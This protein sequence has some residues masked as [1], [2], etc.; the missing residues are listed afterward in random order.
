V[1]KIFSFITQNQILSGTG[2]IILVGIGILLK[3]TFLK[4]IVNAG[5]QPKDKSSYKILFIDDQ[6]FRIIDILKKNGWSSAKR[7]KDISSLDDNDVR[8]SRILF[9]DINGVGK[10]LS[11]TDEGKG[12]AKA[13]REKY[14]KKR[15]VLYS[16]ESQIF[17]AVL[18]M[19]DKCL[20]K[21]AD[22]YEFERIIEDYF[23]KDEF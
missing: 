19:V 3:K 23:E 5:N 18:S 22:Q 2:T 1:E 11:F 9:I 14:P 6:P 12:L 10:S 13:I 15:I 20:Y 21:N 4:D 17:H 16:A 8:E 7:V